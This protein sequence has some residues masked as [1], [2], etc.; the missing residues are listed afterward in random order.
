MERSLLKK[1]L[2]TARRGD[3][4]SLWEGMISRLQIPIPETV[5]VIT[6]EKSPCWLISSETRQMFRLTESN[7]APVIDASRLTL[8]SETNAEQIEVPIIGIHHSDSVSLRQIE[9]DS[10]KILAE[11]SIEIDHS[12]DYPPVL[13]QTFDLACDDRAVTIQI[14]ADDAESSWDVIPAHLFELDRR[15]ELAS[16]K[17]GCPAIIP[18]RPQPPIL[19]ISIDALRYDCQEE[20]RPMI[21]ELEPDA[22]FPSEPRTQGT[23]TPPSHASMFT[24]THPGKHGYVGW[25]EGKGDKRPIDPDLT[26]IPELLSD[27]GYKCSG[28]VSH[29]RI[30]PEFGFGRG[31]HRFYSDRMSFADWITR[32]SDAKASVN[33]LIDWI[34]KDLN[35]R[36]HSLFYF[37]HVFD[38]HYPYI[39]PTESLD[40]PTIDFTKPK[41]Y[42]SQREAARGDNWSYLDGA[43]GDLD[44]DPH[45]SEE[46]KSWYAKSVTY[47]ANQIAKLLQYLKRAGLFDHALIL[48]TG[49]HGEEFGERGFTTHNSLY[50]ENI[51][52]FMAIKPPADSDW[53]SR[54]QVD[55]IDFLPTIAELVNAEV[56]KHCDGT[57]LQTDDHNGIRITERI[58][59][60]WYNVA[61]ES[62]GIKGIF[63]YESNY[64]DRPCRDGIERGPQL[65][66]YYRLERVR[67]GNYGEADIA[68][69]Q[70]NKLQTIIEEFVVDTMKEYT[71]DV[72]A[73]QPSSETMSHLKDLGYK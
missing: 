36:E 32:S 27:A 5:E 20:L 53:D 16:T 63:T 50:D 30:L 48:I 29:T 35:K 26:T 10:G 14:S 69:R 21:D 22:I 41:R 40:S 55:A 6:E 71:A 4:R 23:W 67:S 34:E 59:P 58:Y 25:G 33:T 1:V 13:W 66:E 19:L 49:D 24:G 46:M 64:P 57:A 31:F 65:S 72:T 54:E 73:S 47:T 7:Y 9:S 37:L 62:D 42:W 18:E 68:P 70:K 56:P 17:L 11:T 38:P 12:F 8:Q 43:R 52:P 61:V 28:L 44:I 15:T 45:L 39:P 60:D 51:R 3:L 2:R